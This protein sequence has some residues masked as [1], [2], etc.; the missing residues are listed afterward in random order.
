MTDFHLAQVNIARLAAPLDSPQLAGFVG[1]LVEINALADAS[2][3]F[4]WR[5][6]DEDGGDATS[7]RP[8]D[9]DD[10]LLINC[11]VWESVDALKEYTYR[12][13]HLAFLS[14]RREWFVR[15]TRPHQA[16]WWV[17]AGHRPTTAEAMDRTALVERH[18]PGPEAFT[19]QNPYPAPS[20]AADGV[21]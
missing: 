11:S 9:Q 17:P 7:L 18:G 3:G 13:E 1:G 20:P 4:I 19:F 2:P 8:D 12:S 16:M 10:L 15:M 5:L 21:G 14:R 6:T